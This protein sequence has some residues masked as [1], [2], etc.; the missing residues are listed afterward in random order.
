MAKVVKGVVGYELHSIIGRGGMATVHL[1]RVVSAKGHCRI[2]ALK[3]LHEGVKSDKEIVSMFFDE[4]RIASRLNHPAV[5]G[6]ED[7][8]SD[9]TTT[10]LVMNYIL[11]ESLA[12]LLQ[13]CQNLERQLPPPVVSAIC[14]DILR[15]LHAAHEARDASGRS[16]GLIHRDVSPQNILVG[17]DGYSRL[18]DFGVA[19]ALG[20]AQVT[21]VNVLK[22]KVA[23]MSPEYLEGKPIDKRSDVFALGIVLWETLCGTRLFKGEDSN[24]LLNAVLRMRVPFPNKVRRDLSDETSTV[25]LRALERNPDERYLSALEMVA[26]LEVVLPPAPREAVS[27]W[28]KLLSKDSLAKKTAT[29]R[30]LESRPPPPLFENPGLVP[31]T[32]ADKTAMVRDT[33]ETPKIGPVEENDATLSYSTFGELAPR[34][35]RWAWVFGGLAALTFTFALGALLRPAPPVP[36]DLARPPWP[37]PGYTLL[38]GGALI[39]LPGSQGGPMREG[40]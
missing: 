19:K 20:N 25:V 30:E 10:F 11:G 39:P 31:V 1:G 16:L 29:L 22:G 17:V 2:V 36:P 13:R 24:S 8:V 12:T 23:Y 35:N 38:D 9:G 14:L 27:E 3:Q 37:P 7:V 26:E 21:A 34:K 6:I 33:T 18:I 28:M 32:L 15:G 40:R 4:G 5:V